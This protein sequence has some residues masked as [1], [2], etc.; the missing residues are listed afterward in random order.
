[1]K[2]TTWLENLLRVAVY[3][4]ELLRIEKEELLKELIK[5]KEKEQTRRKILCKP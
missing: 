4:N 3:E 5:L 1:M 2:R